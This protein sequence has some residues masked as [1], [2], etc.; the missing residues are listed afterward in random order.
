MSH[1]PK[2]HVMLA[3]IVEFLLYYRS[4]YNTKNHHNP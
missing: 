2:L 4:Y 3:F 1:I